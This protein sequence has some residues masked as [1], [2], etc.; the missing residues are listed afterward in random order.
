MKCIFQIA[1]VLLGAL[2]VAAAPVPRQHERPVQDAPLETLEKRVNP[3]Q[4]RD[5]VMHLMSKPKF[6]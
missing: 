2:L 1:V 6:N 4:S 3:S 5:I